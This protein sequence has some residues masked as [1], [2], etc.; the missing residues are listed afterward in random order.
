MFLDR[1]SIEISIDENDQRTSEY[2]QTVFRKW[3]EIKK[4]YLKFIKMLKES[5][6]K[7]IDVKEELGYMG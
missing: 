3:N 7:D 4:L 2:I 5:W 1:L 6:L